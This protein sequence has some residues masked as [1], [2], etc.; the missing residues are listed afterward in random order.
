MPFD[1]TNAPASFQGYLNKIFAEKLDIFVIVY[2]DDILIY[3]D[4]DG[5]GHVSA[6]R[7]VLEQLRKFSLFANLKKCRFHQEEVRF[8]GYVVS[9]KGIRMEDERIKAV[10]QWPE[11]QSVRD[12]Q[13]FLGFANFY[14]RFIQGFSRIAAPLTSMLKTLGST[15]SKTQ[16]GE[17]KVGVGGS[18]A[19]CGQRKI[20]GIEIDNVESDGGEVEVDEVGKKVQKL[21]N[22][23]N[24]SKS[25]KTKSGFLTPGV[26]KAF[27][28]LK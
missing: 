22:P 13:V 2:L 27:T 4:D 11:P 6:V 8:L 28:E 19:R 9:S 7:W 25:K 10:K 23:K 15:E 21:S 17:G 5:D 18:R 3:T 16:P 12:I 14:R 1:L 26:E 24:L 20:D